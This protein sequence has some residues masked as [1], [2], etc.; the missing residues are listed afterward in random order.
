MIQQQ[1]VCQGVVYTFVRKYSFLKVFHILKFTKISTLQTL[2]HLQY[3][4]SKDMHDVS[5]MYA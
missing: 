1:L 5:T 4:T 3:L 2:I